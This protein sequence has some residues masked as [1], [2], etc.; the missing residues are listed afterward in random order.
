MHY[1]HA[2]CRARLV[3]GSDPV[4]FGLDSVSSSPLATARPRS[5]RGERLLVIGFAVGRLPAL[6]ANPMLIKS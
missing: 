3:R 4:R 2:V 1:A 6:A 5:D